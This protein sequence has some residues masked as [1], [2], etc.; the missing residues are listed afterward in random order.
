M[1]FPQATA[2]IRRVFQPTLVR[3]T[4]NLTNVWIRTLRCHRQSC[5]CLG[6]RADIE[7]QLLDRA[8]RIH[9]A[10][11]ERKDGFGSDARQTCSFCYVSDL[12]AGILRLMN[13]EGLTEPVNIGRLDNSP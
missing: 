12:I 10:V 11:F 13:T 9:V 4:V 2:H 3:Q 6:V 5:R 8:E 7:H 1:S